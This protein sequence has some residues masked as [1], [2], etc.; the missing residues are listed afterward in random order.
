MLFLP[1]MIFQNSVS[2]QVINFCCHLSEQAYGFSKFSKKVKKLSN[3]L[4]CL[5]MS[6]NALKTSFSHFRT[7]LFLKFFLILL[8]YKLDKKAG[9]NF[10]KKNN[11]KT[12]FL[13]DPSVF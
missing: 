9:F 11:K 5:I 6:A 10:T 8:P 1:K 13:T 7:L 2:W 12:L 3:C 4:N